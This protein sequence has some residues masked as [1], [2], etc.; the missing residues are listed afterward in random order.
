MKKFLIVALLLIVVTA[1][2]LTVFIKI[3]VTPEK[4][5]G[6]IISLAEE[7]L[8]RKVSIGEIDINV[9]KGIG[10]KDFVIKESDGKTD[11]LKCKD[12]VLKFKLMPLLSKRVIIDKL[13]IVS[14]SIRIERNKEGK[15]NFED[16]GKKEVSKEA[17]EA[18]GDEVTEESLISLRVRKVSILDA[19]FSLTD[20]RKELP[21]FKSTTNIDI[22]MEIPDGQEL[23]AEGSVDIKLDEA[24]LRKP[25]MKEIRNIVSKIKF[26]LYINMESEEVRIDKADIEF[27]KISASVKGGL[28]KFSTSPEIDIS[29][30]LTKVNTADIQE[31]AALVTDLKNI[32]LSGSVT[33]DVKLKGNIDKPDTLLVRSNLIMDKVGVKYKD[34]SLNLDGSLELDLKSDNLRIDRA[35]L[36]VEGVP[37]SIK[38]DISKLKTSPLLDIALNLP[39]AKAEKI[40]SLLAQFIQVEGLKLSGTMGADIK[41]KGPSGKLES[42]KAKGN[43]TL[44]KLGVSYN[45]IDALLDGKVKI[46]E[47]IISI[48]LTGSSGRNSARLTG[49][50][51]NYFKNQVIDLNVSS[52][53]LYLDEL[54]PAEKKS[55]PQPSEVAGESEKMATPAK[56]AEP[57]KLK[58]QAKGEVRI[59]SAVYKGMNMTDFY[60]KYLFKDNKLVISKMTAKAGKGKF[61]LNSR[62]DLSTPGYKYDLTTKVDS[63]NA[64]EVVNAFFPKAKDKVF[65]IITTNMKL[66]GKGSLPRS[67][68]RNL[69]ADADFNIKDGKI[70]D[71]ELTRKLSLF[72]NV[73]ELET[74]NFT[75]AGGTVKINRGIAVLNSI[76]KSDDLAMDPKG[77][78][79]LNE[80]LDL[81][82]DLKLSPRL[83]DKAIT[84]KIGKYMKDERGWGTIPILVTGTFSD[85][86]YGPDLAKVG[87]KVIERKINKLLDKL[88]NKDE[89][90]QQQDRQQPQEEETREREPENPVNELLKQLPGLFQ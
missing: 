45:G 78:I 9:L 65:G 69:V 86:E 41:L 35:D 76:F 53:K 75:K 31:L 67:I 68:K 39:P 32:N 83:T 14:P 2:A 73:S 51:G 13:K 77:E 48:D 12:F 20:L 26:A 80:T 8:N 71:A 56:E 59:D 36:E 44:S 63:L 30:N 55:A 17:D 61:S 10:V 4:V 72:M 43:I 60:M 82:F 27:Q 47:K 84:S 79:G 18:K 52:K 49:S 22:N 16:I 46:D 66:S 58:L 88:L 90:P 38:G 42:M 64:D 34:I 21:D 23:F 54:V 87:K 28:K 5:K 19:K 1:I 37:I 33:A 57:L 7:S 50:V 85:P 29:V 81:A 15:Y 62:V 40:Q 11:F 3:Y 70:K 89:R 24:V 25:D 6:L 74:I